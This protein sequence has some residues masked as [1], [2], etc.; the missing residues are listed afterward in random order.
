MGSKFLS[1]G[2]DFAALQTGTFSANLASI[3]VQNLT[4]SFPVRTNASKELISGL[5]QLADCNFAPLTNPVEENLDLGGNAITDLHELILTSNAT[6][7]TPADM[8]TLYTSGDTL[9]Y[10]DD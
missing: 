1:R 10:K 2:G 6:P 5:I 9:H 4:P 7:S 8:L 3:V